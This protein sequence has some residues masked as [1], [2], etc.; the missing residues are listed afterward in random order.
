MIGTFERSSCVRVCICACVCTNS[1]SRSGVK[2]L[3]SLSLTHIKISHPTNQTPI[4]L[5]N[6]HCPSPQCSPSPLF[7]FNM[8]ELSTRAFKW[9]WCPAFIRSFLIDARQGSPRFTRPVLFRGPCLSKT[10]SSREASRKAGGGMAMR[11]PGRY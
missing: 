8:R 7:W 4:H 6:C 11:G 2:C 9:K 3:T 5:S 10:A 1:H